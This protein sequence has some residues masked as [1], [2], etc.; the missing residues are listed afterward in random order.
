[1]KTRKTI[2]LLPACV[3]VA[4]CK[5]ESYPNQYMK[6]AALE[7]STAVSSEASCPKIDP[8]DF[9]KGVSNPY[10][11]PLPRAPGFITETESLK[12]IN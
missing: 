3:G 4:S 6:D 10:I 2:M 1:M 7:Q 12:T 5:K 11:S 8:S 9:V